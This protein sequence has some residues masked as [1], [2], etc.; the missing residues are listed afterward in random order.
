MKKLLA[1]ASTLALPRRM[2]KAGA[3]KAVVACRRLRIAEMC[4]KETL[5]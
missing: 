1:L 4:M 2:T 3:R 5:L